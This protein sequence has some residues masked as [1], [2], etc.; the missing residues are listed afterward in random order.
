MLYPVDDVFVNLLNVR[1]KYSAL[2][3][4]ISKSQP[5]LTSKIGSEYRWGGE[6]DVHSIH[7][8]DDYAATS[9]TE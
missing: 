1:C 2:Q 9:G 5:I 3:Q 4:V 8:E 6:A 7:E